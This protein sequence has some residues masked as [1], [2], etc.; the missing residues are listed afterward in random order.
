MVEKT[1]KS[2]TGRF[3]KLSGND[4]DKVIH[5]ITE[6]ADQGVTDPIAYVTA[7]LKGRKGQKRK[8]VDDAFAELRAASDAR[9]AEWRRQGLLDDT[10]DGGGDDP[11]RVQPEPDQKPKP[12]RQTTRRG[13][14]TISARR[15][16]EIVRP[17]FGN[18]VDAPVYSNGSGVAGES[19][20]SF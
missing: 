14:G 5:A 15:V 7:I 4:Q 19:G 3:L 16:A 11:V 9:K 6:A 12:V 10:G 17:D 13:Y 8:D 2:I 20:I 18:P 1:A